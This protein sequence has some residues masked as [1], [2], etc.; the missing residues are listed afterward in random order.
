[1]PQYIVR[2]QGWAEYLHHVYAESLKR[3]VFHITKHATL[4]S[5]R[6]QHDAKIQYP[7]EQWACV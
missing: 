5:L 6:F 1:M 4:D 7:V 2:V 3:K